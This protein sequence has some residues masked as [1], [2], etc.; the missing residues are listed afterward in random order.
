MDEQKVLVVDDLSILIKERFLVKN[1]SFSLDQGNVLGIVGEDKSGKTS[2]IKALVGS[3]PISD[4]KIYIYGQD[5]Q[6]NP[7]VL[8][9]VGICLD[10]PVFFKF[11]SVLENIKYLSSL[12]GKYNK[13]KVFD[14]LEKFHLKDKANKKV[15]ALSFYERKLMALALAFI[16]EPKLLILDEPFKSLPV[17]SIQKIGDYIQE[18]REKG[19]SIIMTAKK[20]DSL[21]NRCDLY[22]FMADRHIVE[23]LP[24]KDCEKYSNSRT[25]AFVEVKYPHYCGKLIMQQFGFKVKLMGK[26]V[27]FEADEEKTADIVKFFTR[28]KLS[29]Y[30]AGYINSKS[31]RIFAS[32]T[33]YFKEN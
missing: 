9:E 24:R 14:V 29:V 26:R 27:L 30:G 19:I 7:G 10:P 31:E 12:T 11:Q 22:M 25:Y 5:I 21:E 33:P 4:G 3:M 1:V 23:I 8:N 2:L 17:K 6:E 16:N 28:N 18:L 20:Y 32:L 13:Q 15:K